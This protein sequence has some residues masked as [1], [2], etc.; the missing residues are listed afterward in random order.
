MTVK[1]DDVVESPGFIF[2]H[3]RRRGRGLSIDGEKRHAEPI[4]NMLLQTSRY[5]PTVKTLISPGTSAKQ[6]CHG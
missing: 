6:T 3:S 2:R 1:V 5:S 4:S